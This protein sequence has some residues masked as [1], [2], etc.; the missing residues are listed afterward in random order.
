MTLVRNVASYLE[1]RTELPSTLWLDCTQVNY[2]RGQLVG[3]LPAPASQE[4]AR[5]SYSQKDVKSSADC[6]YR[7]VLTL[8]IS[9]DKPPTDITIDLAK[10][11]DYV[12]I[13][14]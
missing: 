3:D 5:L 11:L 8:P 12:E 9:L 1:Q 7:L 4:R 14:R 2:D 13:V 6:E 10:R